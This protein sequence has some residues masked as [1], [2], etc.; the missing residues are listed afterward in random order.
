MLALVRPVAAL[1]AGSIFA[2]A[3]PARA[4]DCV[5]SLAPEREPPRWNIC[6]TVTLD[7][8]TPD[9]RQV[10]VWPGDVSDRFRGSLL[11]VAERNEHA[12]SNRARLKIGLMLGGIPA[13]AGGTALL[14]LMVNDAQRYPANRFLDSFGGLLGGLLVVG[15]TGMVI[16]GD[17]LPAD[18][19]ESRR[20][21]SRP[22]GASFGWRSSAVG[23]SRGTK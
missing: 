2:A 22:Q 7:P 23:P 4:A 13:A 3:A 6:R 9:A 17:A 16:L 1:I 5:P 10:I 8:G 15:G 14:V 21:R 20:R 12:V 18:P 19:L 11:D